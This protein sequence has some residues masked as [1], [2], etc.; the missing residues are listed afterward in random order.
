[1]NFHIHQI[2]VARSISRLQAILNSESEADILLIQEPPFYQ[3]GTQRS[4]TNPTGNV[5]YSSSAHPSWIYHF[6]TPSQH[7]ALPPRVMTYYRRNSPFIFSP[8]FNISS[9]QDLSFTKVSHPSFPAFIIINAGKG[10]AEVVLRPNHGPLL[11]EENGERGSEK[12]LQRP[13]P[14]VPS[15]LLEIRVL[16]A[17]IV[18][19]P[20][21]FKIH[22]ADLGEGVPVEHR[23]DRLRQL[24]AAF[25]VDTARVDP[26][27]SV[28]VGLRD[29]TAPADLLTDVFPR[30]LSSLLAS[31][32]D[33]LKLLEGLFA[34]R[35]LGPG[36]GEDSV[37]SR[38][39]GAV[40]KVMKLSAS[41]AE[42]PHR[43]GSIRRIGQ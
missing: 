25:L 33:P 27:P 23:V 32:D 13:S 42:D 41:S 24:G 20:D 18:P 28:A 14:R 17:R 10:D 30:V 15:R 11:R 8:L 38:D 35:I 4:L 19:I 7:I 9:H 5:V 22:V 6:P 29:F 31:R 43:P 1:M 3:I 34:G 16:T 21:V 26:D 37:S 40:G 39:G 12:L 2:N 36:V